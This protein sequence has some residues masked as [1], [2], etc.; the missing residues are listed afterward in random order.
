MG[1]TE[2]IF[3]S[4]GT[5]D[6][7]RSGGSQASPGYN[8]AKQFYNWLPQLMQQQY[9]TYQGQLDPGMSPTMQDAI[10]RAQGY[11]QSGPAEILQGVQ[12]TLGQF[13]SPNFLNPWNSMRT[14]APNY[15]GY[16]MDTR[17]Y[18]GQPI[19][20]YGSFAGGNQGMGAPTS[21]W[22]QQPGIQPLGG[23]SA[24][25]GTGGGQGFA[26]GAPAPGG[27]GMSYTNRQGQQVGMPTLGG[28]P[29][30]GS[31]GGMPPL[32]AGAMGQELAGGAGSAPGQQP[33]NF[34]QAINMGFND[35]QGALSRM[36]SGN[37]QGLNSALAG[38]YGM[39]QYGQQ[40][41]GRGQ[42]MHS[43]DHVSALQRTLG[44][45]PTFD[46]VQQS[47]RSGPAAIEQAR[48]LFMQDDPNGA[49][50]WGAG[51]KSYADLVSQH[52]LAKGGQMFEQQFGNGPMWAGG[53]PG[54]APTN[55]PPLGGPPSGPIVAPPAGGTGAVP[56][57]SPTDPM[58]PPGGIKV[59]PS[60]PTTSVPPLGAKPGQTY[61]GYSSEQL[62]SNPAL[63]DKLGRNA[64]NRLGL[65][66]LGGGGPTVGGAR[67]NRP[68]STDQVPKPSSTSI[69]GFGPGANANQ[70]TDIGV[71]KPINRPDGPQRI[72]AE[73]PK[74]VYNPKT[75]NWHTPGAGERRQ[76]QKFVRSGG[77]YTY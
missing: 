13:M 68:G 7:I 14:Q 72:A 25:P 1:L 9:P 38:Q 63:A 52:G 71:A 46:E 70:P 40:N 37:S 16:G 50:D 6:Y 77:K 33:G 60:T 18:G 24:A 74:P 27:G 11:A 4:P 31:A 39:N 44:R 51:Q 58:N 53:T 43:T 47:L 35:A 12:G 30:G 75:G 45:E 65:P 15:G 57:M 2:S 55:V 26:P 32:G 61:G 5:T 69:T 59:A 8:F 64:R 67:P 17:A 66:P 49:A 73:Q 19:G 62:N 41:D 21:P 23:S 29:V 22:G 10:R 34:G 54:A 3:G 76:H 42:F 36:F 56:S 28:V 48:T 20:S